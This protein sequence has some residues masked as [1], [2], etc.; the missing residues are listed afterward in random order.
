V[1]APIFFTSKGSCSTVV[2]AETASSDVSVGVPAERTTRREVIVVAEK[3]K[4]AQAAKKPTPKADKSD[5]FSVML[6]QA[7]PRKSLGTMRISKEDLA[8]FV[9]AT[10]K[11]AKGSTGKFVVD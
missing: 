7:N 3:S 9:Q 8:H 2:R 6:L 1:R 10:K 5:T 11:Y 4:K